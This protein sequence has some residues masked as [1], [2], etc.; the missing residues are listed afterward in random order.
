[1]TGQNGQRTEP[2][3]RRIVVV[4]AGVIGVCCAL[5]LRRDGHD[6]TLVDRMSPGEG[7]SFGNAGLLA[8]SSIAPMA[9]PETFAKIPGW[10]LKSDGPLSFRWSYLP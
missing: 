9:I 4:G 8:R 3:P 5:Y 2:C 1:M 10:L 7:C 6:V